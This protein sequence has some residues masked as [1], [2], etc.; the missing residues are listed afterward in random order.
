MGRE[1][2]FMPFIFFFLIVLGIFG[3]IKIS[4]AFKPTARVLSYRDSVCGDMFISEAIL[5]AQGS[6]C[7]KVGTLNAYDYVCNEDIGR[8]TFPMELDEE[9]EGV[10]GASCHVFVDSGNIYLQL[11]EEELE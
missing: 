9:Q 11:D 3:F 6:S 2:K 7:M 10:V 1:R 8:I 5:I 4:D